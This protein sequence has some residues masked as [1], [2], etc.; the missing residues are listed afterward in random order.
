L[1]KRKFNL[2]RKINSRVESSDL[3]NNQEFLAEQYELILKGHTNSRLTVAIAS[4][5]K[6]VISGSEDRAVRVWN[7]DTKT[8]QAVFKCHSYDLASVAITSNNK[9]V[10]SDS[11]DCTVRIWG[12]TSEGSSLKRPCI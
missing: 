1:S 7:V 3:S 4:D 6:Y 5:N 8:E 11:V 12:L 9:F 2:D 10:V